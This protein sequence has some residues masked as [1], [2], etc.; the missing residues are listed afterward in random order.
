MIWI[1]VEI[2][3]SDFYGIHLEI[4]FHFLFFLRNNLITD[5]PNSPVPHSRQNDSDF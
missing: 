3:S 4:A 5:F 2:D 1:M